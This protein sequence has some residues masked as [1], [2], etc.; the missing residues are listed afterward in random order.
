MIN[1]DKSWTLFLDR[2]GVINVETLDEYILRWEDFIFYEGAKEALAIFNKL[3]SH[4]IIV[5]NQ[6]CIGKGMME[7]NEL[8]NI[9]TKM[10]NAIVETNGKIDRVYFCG[11]FDKESPNHKPNT[12]MA[13]QAQHD[14]PEIDFHKSIMIGNNFSDMEFGKRMG[15]FTIFISSTQE[16]PALPHDLIDMACADLLSAAKLMVVS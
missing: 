6:R 13:L 5:T 15:M 9:H 12:G 3:F 16:A 11:D 4:I 1:I 8:L 7:E 2:D 10:Q 14:F